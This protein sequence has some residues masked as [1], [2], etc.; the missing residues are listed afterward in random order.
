MNN[1]PILYFDFLGDTVKYSNEANRELVGRYTNRTYINRRG[2]EKNNKDYHEAFAT[3]IQRLDK[4][5]DNFVFNLDSKA[6]EG[7][8]SYDGQNV[9]V[10]IGDPRDGYG[11]PSG[12][13]GIL[14]EET[15]HAEQVLDGKA[16]L[17]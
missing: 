9:N 17:D 6:K 16:V 14:F 4:G 13:A 7:E 5:E 11:T 1:S 15:K 2:K 10:T 12:I 3:I 8:V